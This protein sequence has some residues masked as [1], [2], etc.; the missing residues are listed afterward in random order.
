MKTR[1]KCPECKGTGT[2]LQSAKNAP[3][4]KCTECDGDGKTHQF[5]MIFW[6][7][8]RFPFV[9]AARGFKSKGRAYIPSFNSHFTPCK[10]MPLKAGEAL[11]AELDHLQQTHDD[12]ISTVRSTFKDKVRAIAPWAIKN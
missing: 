4:L 2:Y 6:H 10:V 1:G 7:Y 12:I 3:P 9:L 8:D 11:K 5:Q